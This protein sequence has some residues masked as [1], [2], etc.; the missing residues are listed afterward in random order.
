MKK[1][2]I[3]KGGPVLNEHKLLPVAGL[4]FSAVAWGIIWYPYRLLGGIGVSGEMAILVT[5]LV[6]LIAT[7]VFSPHAWRQF[8]RAPGTLMVVAIAAGWC[9]LAYV[10]GVLSGEVMRV[11]LL[12]YLAPLWTVPFAR[13][14][15]KE[16]ISGVGYLVV[17]FA[18]CGAVV[19]LWNPVWG[20]PMPSTNAEWL[21][22][23]SGFCFALA[24]VMIRRAD[25][26]GVVIKSLTVFLGVVLAA[27]CAALLT[28][29]VTAKAFS[30]PYQAM[31]LTLLIGGVIVMMSLAIN[32]GLSRVPATQAIVILLFELVVAAFASYFLAG[33]VMGLKQWIG[34]AMI[35]AASLFSSQIKSV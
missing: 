26:C 11:T 27:L 6:A 30:F 2:R 25:T 32:Y 33:E 31:P 1:L 29:N 8:A 4:L 14:I 20:L 7:T 24:N 19:M 16:R 10:L 5:Y 9:N 17:F 21:G 22:L 12:F 13:V 35:V 15:L 3:I 28:P 34:G 18:F 23:S